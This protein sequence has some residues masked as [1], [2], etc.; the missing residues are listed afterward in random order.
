M[1]N[2]WIRG[3]DEQNTATGWQLDTVKANPWATSMGTEPPA[4]GSVARALRESIR[5]KVVL[6]PTGSAKVRALIARDRYWKKVAITDAL[7]RRIR[8]WPEKYIK[9]LAEEILEAMDL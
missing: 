6:M 4:Q 2:A 3:A 1:R 7:A 5:N 8:G 9:R